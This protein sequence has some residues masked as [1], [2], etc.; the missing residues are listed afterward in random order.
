MQSNKNNMSIIEKAEARLVA[1]RRV[2]QRHPMLP[3]DAIRHD[4]HVKALLEETI[5]LLKGV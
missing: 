3:E 5:Q 1:A 2:Q 4:K